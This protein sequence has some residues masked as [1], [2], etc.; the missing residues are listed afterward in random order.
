M[1]G[2]DDLDGIAAGIRGAGDAYAARER[3]E[4]LM[5]ISVGAAIIPIV[6]LVGAWGLSGL[7]HPT[8]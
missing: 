8:G 7:W 3:G 5:S 1:K 4:A 6:S 2:G